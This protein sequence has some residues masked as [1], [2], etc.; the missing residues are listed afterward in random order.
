MITTIRRGI[1][2]IPSGRRRKFMLVGMLALVVTGLE[3][4]SALVVLL[5]MRLVLDGGELPPLPL[6][7]DIETLLP[8]MTYDRLV[9][10]GAFV[11]GAF[12]VIRAIIFLFQQ[13]AMAKVIENTGVAL[14]A[15][16]V[17]GYLS[18]P[19]EFHLKRNSS[20]LI[21]NAY[22]NVQQLIA[23]VFTPILTILAEVF[24]VVGLLLVLVFT[25]PYITLITTVGMGALVIVSL[26]TVQP[27][28]RAAGRERQQSAQRTL[29]YL[30]QG[31]EGFRD[32][33]V[34]GRERAFGRSFVDVR[35]T[36]GRAQ[37][38]RAALLYV[39]RVMLET[40]F[41]LAIVVALAIAVRHGS[42][43]G[44]L[45]TLGLFA[46]AGLR[47]QPSLQKI[48]I[49]IN[50][51]RYAEAVVDDLT[52]ELALI[53]D[54]ARRGAAEVINPAPLPFTHAVEFRA[55]GFRYQGADADALSDVNIVI[56]AGE[57]IGICGE[58][59]GGKS[60]F[61]DLLCGLLEPTS[62]TILVDGVSLWGHTRAWQQNLG[63]VHQS[64]FL[65]D[66]TLRKNIALGV[67]DDS[68]DEDAVWQA[69]NMSELGDVVADLPNG[70]DTV[71]GERGAR[72][73]GG[74]RQRVTL[75]R[76]L[77]RRPAMLALD[78][79]TSALDNATEAKVMR[80]LASLGR[81]STTVIVAHRLS[82]IERCDQI[83]YMERG[84]V[85]ATGT[86]RELTASHAGFRAIASR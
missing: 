64:A 51:I 66:D 85:V 50:S 32:V 67:S 82:T 37:Y 41:L 48:A 78:E 61:L 1:A 40:S 72:L 14:S 76:A 86:Y 35:S 39:P 26:I 73:S 28:L 18:M 62:G 29:Q 59:G 83:V 9:T 16:L 49:A 47:L 46:Y 77:Y 31:F 23:S 21:R 25:S 6:I 45:A 11:F 80:N 68:I 12:F 69:I 13:Y 5:L 34:L 2:L 42:V 84:Y 79:G 54:A 74:Q 56:R 17:N 81:G 53:S 75:A 10:V 7:G 55:V 44:M 63:V 30:Q 33:K 3:A 57:S 43:G 52:N 38:R 4:V 70:L 36:M 20:E 65:T 60:T 19:Y 27:R 15:R 24:M 58:T 22:D 71:V 8:R